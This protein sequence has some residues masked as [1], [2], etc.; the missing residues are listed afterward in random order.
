MSNTNTDKVYILKKD[1]P[2]EILFKR[3][4]NSG[5]YV[6]NNG[7]VFSILT[8]KLLRGFYNKGYLW[9][10]LYINGEV[11]RESQHR[12]MAICFIPNPENLPIVRHL[13]DNKYDIRLDNLAW[14]TKSDNMYDAVLN[15]RIENRPSPA[16]EKNKNAKLSDE[17][18][19][20]IRNE[21][22]SGVHLKCISEKYGI[23][24]SNV[25]LI[26]NRRTWKHI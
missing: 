17:L 5:Y 7:L 6:S 3:Y 23:A 4:K 9:F 10:D 14:G 11:E 22:N 15:G 20:L 16:G 18:V 19:L 1:L 25:Y 12:L 24:I 26:K 13:N 2:D 21:I 8:N